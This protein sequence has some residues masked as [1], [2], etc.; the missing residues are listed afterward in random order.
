MPRAA[1]IP[2]SVR[3][4]GEFVL[5]QLALPGQPVHDVGVL[6]VDADRESPRHALRLRTHWEDLAK[7]EDAE[8]LAALE[9]DFR[10]KIAEMG[11]RGLLESWEDSLSHVLR[12]SD[13]EAVAVDSFSRVADRLFEEHVEPL[14]V[15]R[16]RTHLPLYTLRA[17]AGKFGAEEQVEEED[18]V[19]VPE[20][21]RL[22]DGMFVAH[23]VGRS[24]EP[25][26]PDGSLNIFRAPVVGSR[27]GKIVLVEV[28]GAH[29]KYTVK[30]Y[31]SRKSFAGEDEWQ[32]EEIRLLPL[33]PEFEPLDLRPDQ[34]RVIAEWIE[35][36]E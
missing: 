2:I 15:E 33:N 1:V 36:L 21:L 19:R 31:T 10:D 9:Q 29:E 26:I 23:V 7:P 12:V 30:K 18:C 8:Y 32:H 27:Q 5:L 25:R 11:A 34:L 14:V 6:L 3:A 20:H 35:T 22:T 4:R 17:A 13:R 24:M 16:F 28:I